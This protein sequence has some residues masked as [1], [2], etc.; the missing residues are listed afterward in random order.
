MIGPSAGQTPAL[1]TKEAPVGNQL[2]HDVAQVHVHRVMQGHGSC[3][4]GRRRTSKRHSRM[5]RTCHP[6]RGLGFL[7]LVLPSGVSR[8]HFFALGLRILKMWLLVIWRALSASTARKASIRAR[9]WTA[10][11]PD[12]E[13]VC[14]AVTSSW[15]PLRDK[16]TNKAQS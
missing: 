14:G 6:L 16:L 11:P 10:G 2:E 1:L 9:R 12:P 15:Y 13:L 8:D 4:Q 3:A 5:S 7:A